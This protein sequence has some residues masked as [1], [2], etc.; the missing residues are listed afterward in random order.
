MLRD[1]A[2]IQWKKFGEINISDPFFDSL[3]KAYAEFPAWFTRKADELALVVYDDMEALQGFLYLK[4]E[5]GPVTDTVPP[6]NAPAV[7]KVGTFKIDAHGTRLGERFVKKLFDCTLAFGLPLAYVTI[8]PEHAGLISLL[9]RYGF[10]FYGHKEG[11]NGRENVYVKNLYGLV[12]DPCLDFP[13]LN[14]SGKRKWL[15]SIRPDFHSRL[16]PDSLLRTETPSVVK[17]LSYANSIHKVY[18]SF[19]P[20]ASLLQRGDVVV[21][22][23]T[24]EP[25]KHAEFSS[26][27]SSLCSVE[28]VRSRQT[29]ANEQDFVDYCIR[30]SVFSEPELREWY[31]RGD[32]VTTIRM[33]YNIALPKRPNRRALADEVGLD[34]KERWTLLPMTDEQFSRLLVKGQVYEGS[35]IDQAGVR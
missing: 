16:F 10:L 29:F 26:V 8:F 15:L 34:R 22:Y 1:D 21:I 19:A 13:V 4:Q 2:V 18:V 12:G 5:A 3:K 30:H 31:R 25:G 27:A 28:E 20:N 6:I 33:T 14:A 32:N 11:P 9:E 23:R 35:V 24:A 17:D 7:M